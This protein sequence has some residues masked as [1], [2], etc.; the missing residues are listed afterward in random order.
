MLRFVKLTLDDIEALRPYFSENECRINDCTIGGTFIWRDYH[1]TE[2]AIDDDGTLFFK[3][4]FP[5]PALTPP[6]GIEPNK[7]SYERIIEYCDANNF[8]PRIFS[9]SE[10]VLHGII[11]LFPESIVRT[12]RDTCDYL[13]KSSDLAN[14][15]GRKYSG[16]RNHINR[17]IREHPKWS[18]EPLTEE[19]LPDVKAFYQKFAKENI[20]DAFTYNEGNLKSEEVLDNFALYGQ[21]GGVL[22]VRDVIVGASFGEVVGDTLFVHNEKADVAYHGSYPMLVNQYAKMYVTDG[23]DY[24]NREEDDGVEGLRTS[25]LS[26]H[27][28]ALLDKYTIDLKW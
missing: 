18:F 16:Q 23:I 2:Y 11:E 25:K 26:Y 14:L 27:P 20:K 12:N 19:L 7:E 8:P 24:I 10:Q 13:Y 9:V 4:A 21:Y 3:V 17:F 6:R 1:Q 22:Y 5:E 15:A 28:Y